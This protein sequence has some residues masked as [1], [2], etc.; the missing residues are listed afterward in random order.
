[1]GRLFIGH[2]LW[3][4]VRDVGGPFALVALVLSLLTGAGFG[5]I[6]EY[7][8]F[9][10]G[11]FDVVLKT[12]PLTVAVMGMVVVNVVPRKPANKLD[13]ILVSMVTFLLTWIFPIAAIWLSN[14]LTDT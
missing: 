6:L 13:E 7:L 8:G 1:V 9:A 4:L 10:S 14:T 2:D 3:A 5:A 11:L 12:W